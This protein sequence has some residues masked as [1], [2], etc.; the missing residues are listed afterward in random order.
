MNVVTADEM[1]EIDRRSIEDIGIPGAVLME[2]AGSAVVRA[3]DAHFSDCQYIGIFVGKGN[4]GGDGLVVARQ[5]ANV[6]R[7]VQIFLVSPPDRFAGDA[8]TNLRIAQNLALPI[9]QILSAPDLQRQANEIATCTLIVDA[10]FGTGLRGPVRGPV[11][12]IVECI[13]DAGTPVIAVD[14]PSGLEADTGMAE[15]VCIQ[16]DYTVTMGLPKRGLLIYPGAEFAGALEVA[17]IGFPP[18]VIAEQNVQVNRTQLED[19]ARWAPRRYA[20]SHKGTYGRVFVVAGSTGMTGA[21]SLTS[22]AALRAGAGLVTLGAPRSL[23]PVLEIK[24]TEVMTLP[25]A[26]TP[27]G[28]LAPAA[29]SRILEFVN[30]TASILA[31]GPGLS[32]HPETVSL[33]HDLLREYDGPMVIDADGLNAISGSKDLLRSLPPQTVIT[34]HPGELR[35]LTGESVAELERDRIGFAQQF[36]QEYDITLVSKGA[37]TIIAGGNGEVWINATGNPGMSTGGMGD[38]LTGVIAGLMAQETPSFEAAVLGVYLHGLA[39]DIAA[40]S[41]GMPGLMAGDVLNALPEAIS[42]V[43]IGR[44]RIT[45]H[46]QNERNAYENRNQSS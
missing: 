8:L 40:E 5:L 25:L 9:T 38:V 3:I 18:T 32:Q 36:A 19:A 33:V 37:P 15:G 7:R 26:E 34:P 17:D 4:N 10:I 39:G 20:D 46:L 21:A 6:G 2:N 35:R 24:L 31:I 12:D 44:G 43:S 1:R 11:V 41:R 27:E 23:N 28:S 13:N 42:R 14:L 30:R 22:E 45:P 29:A 16:A